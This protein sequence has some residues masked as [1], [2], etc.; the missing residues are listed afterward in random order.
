MSG[1]L[2]DKTPSGKPNST[3]AISKGY[4][5]FSEF[6]GVLYGFRLTPRRLAASASLWS[7]VPLRLVLVLCFGQ[8]LHVARIIPAA[9]AQGDD[10]VHFTLVTTG[11]FG[12]RPFELGFGVRVPL[13]LTLAVARAALTFD[14]T[15]TAAEG[16]AVTA[17]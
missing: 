16:A 17:R 3:P 13:D 7:K 15:A 5:A 6:I 10:V 9:L 12:I 1:D 14:G 8:P 11:W 2:P 4:T